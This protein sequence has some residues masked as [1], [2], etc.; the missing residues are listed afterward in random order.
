[1]VIFPGPFCEA[2]GIKVKSLMKASSPL[3]RIEKDE[4]LKDVVFELND[5]KE[6]FMECILR[7]DE[8]AVYDISMLPSLFAVKV[9][10]SP[11]ASKRQSLH[12]NKQHSMCMSHFLEKKD[13]LSLFHVTNKYCQTR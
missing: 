8:K 3:P 9:S 6:I 2:A 13:V 12:R 5:R 1:M 11:F 4:L 10:L 7:M